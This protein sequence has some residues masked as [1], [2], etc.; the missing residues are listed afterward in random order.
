[1][2]GDRHY[3]SVLS[4]FSAVVNHT[5]HPAVALPLTGTGSPPFS[6]QVIGP[7]GSETSR[8]GFARGLERSEI[9][10]FTPARSNSQDRGGDTIQ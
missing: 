9:S 4:Y 6:L 3:R 2:I 7:M 10:S 1:M 5:L 8:L